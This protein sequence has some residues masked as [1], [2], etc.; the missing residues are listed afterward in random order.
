MNQLKILFQQVLMISTGILFIV[1]ING[2]V[3]HL[4]GADFIFEW[5]YPFSIIL[6]GLL[7]SLPTLLFIFNGVFKKHSIWNLIL[8]FLSEWLI[9]VVIGW[10]FN[11]YATIKELLII[12]V[13]EIAVY[14]FVWVATIWILRMEDKKINQALKDIQDKE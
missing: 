1:G 13:E 6:L 12:T 9:T 4:T 2:L 14:T 3:S 11:W 8:H 10:I 7:C 5:Y